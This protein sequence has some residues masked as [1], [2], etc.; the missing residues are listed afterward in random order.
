MTALPGLDF[1]SHEALELYL[2]GEHPLVCERLLAY[3]EHLKSVCVVK[4]DDGVRL[5]LGEFCHLFAFLFTRPDFVIPKEMAGKFITCNEVVGNLFAMSD[6]KTTDAAL[7]LLLPNMERDL[8]KVLTLFS[9]RNH[10]RL[11][12]R[13]FFDIDP[14]M[15]TVWYYNFSGSTHGYLVNP[16][17]LKNITEHY[18]FIDPRMNTLTIYVNHAYFAITYICPE[19]NA[20]VKFHINQIVRGAL[21]NMVI[22]NTPN[23][24]KRRIAVFTDRWFHGHVVYRNYHKFLREISKDYDLV[25]I[26]YSGAKSIDEHVDKSMFS[27]IRYLTVDNGHID[28]DAVREN[29][30]HAAIFVDIGMSLESIIAANLRIAPIQ[31]VWNGHPVSTFGAEVDYLVGSVENFK[32][33]DPDTEFSERLVMVPGLGTVPMPPRG[34]PRF[35]PRDRGVVYINC[36]WTA[37]KTNYPHLLRLRAIME[38]CHKTIRFHF[39][40]LLTITKNNAFWNYQQ[41]IF[42]V[43]GEENVAVFRVQN[44]E[45]L[46]EMGKGDLMIESFPFGGFNSVLDSLYLC[47]PVL[48]LEGK[49]Q[50]SRFGSRILVRAG[51]DE[52]VAQDEDELI[53]KAVRLID[54]DDYRNELSFRIG[55]I[56]LFSKLYDE[57]ESH[58]YKLAIDYLFEHHEHLKQQPGRSPILIQP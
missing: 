32:S 40:P 22:I 2:K 42:D 7:A 6:L 47:R 41:A 23:P 16:H 35:V 48:T 12:R 31:M 26:G 57:D 43:L 25:L 50:Y 33:C 3:L 20:R 58:Y 29:D 38:R 53:R 8:V 18:D 11:D 46:Q 14:H 37:Q 39:F 27:E 24:D 49:Y 51:L 9:P 4:V 5:A 17:T 34:R 54:D 56:D 44:E 13:Q 15:A 55:Q 21:G 30:F 45:Y 1:N 28:L 19:L 10:T 52:L 36:P